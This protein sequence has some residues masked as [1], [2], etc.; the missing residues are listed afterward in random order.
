MNSPHFSLPRRL[1]QPSFIIDHKT[2]AKQNIYCRIAGKMGERVGRMLTREIRL[3]VSVFG[4]F[5][6]CGESRRQGVGEGANEK[7]GN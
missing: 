7:K 1:A 5:N 4:A 3:F 2:T 6:L